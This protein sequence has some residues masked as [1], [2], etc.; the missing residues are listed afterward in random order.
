MLRDGARVDA[1]RARQAD[2]ARRQRVAR[3][4][5]D[6]RADRLDEAEPRRAFEQRVPPETGHHQHIRLGD[7]AIEA[8]GIAHLEAPDAA[9]ERA[10]HRSIW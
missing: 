8:L 3:K 10:K 1:A 5:V 9:A 2:A 7:A 6:S 4:L